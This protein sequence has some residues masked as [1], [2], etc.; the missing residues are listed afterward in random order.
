MEKGLCFCFAT[1]ST[2]TL[3]SLQPSRQLLFAL[4]DL[5][6]QRRKRGKQRV[7]EAQPV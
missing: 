4:V 1:L 5:Q 2:H 3:L 7:N 6:G